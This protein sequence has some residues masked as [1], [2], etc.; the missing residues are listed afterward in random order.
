[1]A[2][3]RGYGQLT[4]GQ[5]S[6]LSTRSRTTSKLKPSRQWNG[7]VYWLRGWEKLT[8][9]LVGYSRRSGGLVLE[10]LGGRC[11]DGPLTKRRQV[12]KTEFLILSCH[13]QENPDGCKK[14]KPAM[15]R[16]HRQA[17]I[18]W[19]S[20]QSNKDPPELTFPTLNHHNKSLYIQ[21]T[22]SRLPMITRYDVL[23]LNHWV[24]SENF[25]LPRFST[26]YSSEQHRTDNTGQKSRQKRC[27][28]SSLTGSP[29][30]PHVPWEISCSVADKTAKWKSFR[31]KQGLYRQGT[32]EC[33]HLSHWITICSHMASRRSQTVYIHRW[34]AKLILIFNRQIM[35]WEINP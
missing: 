9:A 19:D 27:Q 6:F 26:W 4:S 34:P 24:W 29:G 13:S 28:A 21:I 10:R 31:K 12:Q 16:D 5:R 15:W 22:I 18:G 11:L 14:Q 33:S 20:C 7:N 30:S 3:E 32:R 17:V 25:A 35:F 23:M 8:W 1:M 2:A